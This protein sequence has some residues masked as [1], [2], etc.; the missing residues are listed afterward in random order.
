MKNIKLKAEV[1]DKVYFYVGDPTCGTIT[2][3]DIK[4]SLSEYE[5]ISKCVTY[6]IDQVHVVMEESIYLTKAAL[7]KESDK[8]FDNLD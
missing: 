1:G 8:I 4:L 3:I 7:K 2:S 5:K 6:K